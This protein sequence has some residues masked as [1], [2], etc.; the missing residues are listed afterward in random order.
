M[1]PADQIYDPGRGAKKDP[2]ETGDDFLAIGPALRIMQLNVEGL[3]AAK[4]EVISSIAVR[5]KIDVICLEE[6]H[7]H[8]DKTNH[9]S[10]AG[11]DLLAYSLHTKYGRA[12]YVRDNISD[13]HHVTSS[14]CY[15]VIRI[16][17][18]R[19]ANI[20]KPPSEKCGTTNTLPVLPH[21]SLLVGDFNSH[22]PD[23][24]YQVPDEDG[25]MLQDW[26]SGNHF[27]IIHDSKQRGTFH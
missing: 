25:K 24:G 27:H 17:S 7:V 10:I 15:D 3:S 22:H 21:P 6:T 11:F 23:W 26:A 4:R 16:G 12:T 19:V 20:Y 14:V 8:V 1:P 13:A 9:F 18:Y 5:Q 2:T